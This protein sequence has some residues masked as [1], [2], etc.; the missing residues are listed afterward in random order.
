MQDLRP[1]GYVVGLMV[2]TLGVTMCLPMFVDM[3]QMSAQN[4]DLGPQQ[5]ADHWLVFAK[6]AVLTVVIGGVLALGGS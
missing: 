4:A 1:V 6:S 3:A 5:N 2:M